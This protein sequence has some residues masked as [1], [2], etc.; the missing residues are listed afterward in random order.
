RACVLNLVIYSP[1]K[2]DES[3]LTQTIAETSMN[4]P[5]RILVLFAANESENAPEIDAS[6]N[7]L[8][9]FQPGGRKQVCC[10][11]IRIQSTKEGMR[12]VP[13]IVVPLLVPDLPVI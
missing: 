8:C 7:A 5:G 13:G 10:E 11:E 9:H 4:H 3:S 12:L 1:D 2:S 6:V